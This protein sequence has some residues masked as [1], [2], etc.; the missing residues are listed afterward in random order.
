MLAAP[1]AAGGADGESLVSTVF[2]ESP[3]PAAGAS[4]VYGAL[5][6]E[7]PDVCAGAVAKSDVDDE[8]LTASN[9]VLPCGGLYEYR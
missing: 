9:V 1:A 8:R 3:P 6:S 7:V 4:V 2:D 5:T